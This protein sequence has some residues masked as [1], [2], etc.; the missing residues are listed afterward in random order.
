M[1]VRDW[2]KD[3]QALFIDR[4]LRFLAKNVLGQSPALL[5]EK[6]EDITEDKQSYLEEL[7]NEHAKG[8][9]LAYL[10]EKEEFMGLEFKVNP[11]VLIP[12]KETE[13]VVEKALEIIK[14]SNTQQVLDLGTGSGNIAV[15]IK[16]E[17]GSKVSVVSSD[18]SFKALEVACE[19][20]KNH[21]VEVGLIAANLLDSFKKNCFDLIIS[22]PPYVAQDEIKGTLVYEPRV[23]LEAKGD[24]F[25]II[26]KILKEAPLYLKRGGHLIVEVGYN[27][28]EMVED[29][30]KE[31]E[32]YDSME[33]IRDYA[34][35][36]RAI[37]LCLE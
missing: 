11:N 28:K 33:W 7:K 1:K 23:A 30:V 16:K 3:N 17:L 10:L 12:R 34:G 37:V 18:I 20:I 14:E 13:L 25:S 21:G 9:P 19:N 15:T 31:L 32:I 5:L 26:E 35:H 8:V 29:A 22:N 36:Y 2:F 4:D 27:H 6:E 24:G